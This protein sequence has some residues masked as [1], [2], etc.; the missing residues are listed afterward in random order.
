MGTTT[1]ETA[2][3]EIETQREQ[4]EKKKK[5][6]LQWACRTEITGLLACSVIKLREWH[7]GP[8]PRHFC[9]C[10]GVSEY[11]LAMTE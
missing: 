5:L 9:G 4:E 11:H 2:C 8:W 3:T 6:Q 10:D 7:G 1:L